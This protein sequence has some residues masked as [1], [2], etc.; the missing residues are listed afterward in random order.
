MSM[1]ATRKGFIRGLAGIAACAGGCRSLCGGQKIRLGVVGTWGKG[2]SDWLTMYKS[3]H[4]EIAAFC[5]ADDDVQTLVPAALRRQGVDL[6]FARVPFYTDYRRLLDDAGILGL[7]AL[8]VSTPDHTHAAV[9]IRAMKMGLHVYVQKPLVRTL[10]ELELFRRTAKANGV[11]TQMGNQGSAHSGLRRSVEVIRTGIIGDV[12]EI[13][14]WT[15]RPIWPQGAF[16]AKL[17]GGKEDPIPTG[18]NWQAWLGP[19]PYVKF[20]G[21]LPPGT[22]GFDPRNP[23]RRFSDNVY[24]R[25]N[26]RGY[27]DFGCGAFGDMACHTMNM[28]FR[29]C[30]LGAVDA[31]ECIQIDESTDVAFPLRSIV[32]LHYKARRSVYRP[33][34]VLPAVDLYWYDGN[35]LPRAELMPQVVAALGAVPKTGCLIVGSKGVVCSTDD[36]G[37][38]GYLALAGEEKVRDIFFHPACRD[39]PFAIPRRDDVV[40]VVAQGP[41]APAVELDGHYNE[42]LDAIRGV[43][44]VFR[45]TK[46]RCFSDVDFSVPIME[47]ILVGIAAQRLPSTKLRWDSATQ[48]FDDPRANAFVSYAPRKGFEF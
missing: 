29:A 22:P 31:A 13:H 19:V 30:E 32:K 23:K 41:G 17:A 48:S 16:A 45:D 42:F 3:G 20:K 10:G 18:L 40:D 46:S 33:E 11:I 6:D 7:D 25:F 14:V 43:G 26:W 27:F 2:F 37:G 39:I 28:P 44:P 1:N 9:A 35:Q 38:T 21:A 8:T 36:Y 4:V 24:H 5:D 34:V 47:G 15:N 12:K